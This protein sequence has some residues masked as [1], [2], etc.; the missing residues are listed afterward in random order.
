MTIEKVI[1]AL[2]TP[3]ARLKKVRA[4][5]VLITDSGFTCMAR[6]SAKTVYSCRGRN[7]GLWIACRDGRHMLD[8]QL[9]ERGRLIGLRWPKPP[10][11]NTLDGGLI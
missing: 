5:D 1:A 11:S 8:G 3:Y 7:G 6:N 9:D 4:G 2:V 10:P